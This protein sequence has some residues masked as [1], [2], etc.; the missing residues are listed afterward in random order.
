MHQDSLFK[1]ITPQDKN[2]AYIGNRLYLKFTDGNKSI[3]TLFHND[4][5]VKSIDFSDQVAKRILIVE[6][7]ELGAK[8]SHLAEAMGICR[9][10]IDNYL[11]A[12]KHFGFEGLINNY[13]PSRSINIRKHRIENINNRHTGNKAKDIRDI[14]QKEQ[15]TLPKQSELLFGG[16][17]KAINPEDQPFTEQHGWKPTRYAG[18]FTYLITLIHLNDWL[19]MIMTYFGDKYKIFLVFLLLFAKGIRSIEQLKNVVRREAGLVLGLRR[20]P[21]KQQVR[22]WLHSACTMQVAGQLTT[23]FFHKQV[24]DGIVGIWLWFT[25]GHLLPY[26]GKEKTHHGFNTQRQLMVPGRTNQVTCDISGRVVDFEIQEGK[27]DMRSYLVTL[28][29]KWEDVIDGGPIMVFDREG[30]GAEFFFNM[31]Q[32]NIIFVTWEKHIDTK[33][34]DE[35]QPDQF[36][37]EFKVNEKTYRVFEDKKVFTHTLENK[38]TISFALRR[39]YIWN[40]T[41]NRKTCALSNAGV[42]KMD[43][44]ECATAIL[45]RWGASENTFKHLADKH[46]LNYQPGYEFVESKNQSIVNPDLKQIKRDLKV[47]KKNLEKLCKKLSKTSDVFNKDGS[48]RDNSKHQRLKVKI[49]DEEAHIEHLSQKA[50]QLPIRIDTSSLEDYRC[51]QRISD[52]SKYLFDFVTSSAWNARKQMVE[53]LSQFYDSKN[54]YVDL[55]YAITNCHGWIRSEKDKVVVRLE[56]LQQYSRHTAQIQFCRKLT[57]LAVVTPGGKILEIEVG[58][59]PID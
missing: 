49:R 50:K 41:S 58:D 57:Q 53:W 13:S 29:K 24:S 5:L 38:E 23:E 55:F 34:L 48:I 47:K 42:D 3:V 10:S 17:S 31:N 43:A 56:P 46:P 1:D 12:K 26:T 4:V 45:N 28:G 27:G 15:E 11:K 30:Y 52:E 25:D 9:Q 36:K 39:I 14:R 59:S 19:G 33:K 32:A 37:E 40:V 18:A 54:E 16:H 21:I 51:F 8:K 22:A 35:V 6:A 2:V 44:R 7:V 20:L